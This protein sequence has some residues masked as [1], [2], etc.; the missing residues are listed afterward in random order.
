[1]PPDIVDHYIESIGETPFFRSHPMGEAKRRRDAGYNEALEGLKL[2]TPS[3]TIQV[4]WNDEESATPFGQ[5]PFFLE[6]LNLTGLWERWVEGCPLVYSSPNAPDKRDVMGTWLLSILSGHKRYAHVTAIRGDGVN[7]GLLRMERVISEDAL[8]RALTKIPEESGTEWLREHLG[9]SVLPLLNAPWILDVDT[10]IKPLY[11][12]QE[13]AEKGF[14]PKKPGRPSHTYHSY[15]VAGLRLVLDAEVLAGNQSQAKH[16]MPGLERL[17]D[18]LS[19]AGKTP[20][21]TR[22]DAGFGNDP[23]IRALEDRGRDYLF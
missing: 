3:G 11:G 20:Y 10:T 16:T 14:N 13:G 9:Q 2:S 6:F 12:K 4:R 17:L 1:L 7:P 5:L 19:A 21:L 8:R 22:G 15:L 18:E 23:V